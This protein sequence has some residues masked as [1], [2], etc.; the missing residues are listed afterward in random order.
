VSTV[1]G[2]S[3]GGVGPHID[4]DDSGSDKNADIQQISADTT[5]NQNLH[6]LASSYVDIGDSSGP[7]ETDI[8]ETGADM[9]ANQHL[10][11]QSA[12]G[13]HQ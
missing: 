2:V 13:K 3:T 5:A 4:I 1:G 11:P 7:K 8:Q 6:S 10:L 9:S 12:S